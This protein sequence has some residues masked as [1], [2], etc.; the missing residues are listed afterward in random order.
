MY[1]VVLKLTTCQRDV[2]G[3]WHDAGDYGR[4]VVTDLQI[5]V[6]P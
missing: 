6:N 3:G 1:C 5:K 4:Y 2:S